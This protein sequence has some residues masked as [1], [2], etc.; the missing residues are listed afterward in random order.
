[1]GWERVGSPGAHASPLKNT[2]LMMFLISPVR[3][4]RKAGL[5]WSISEVRTSWLGG[6]VLH[7]GGGA[8]GLLAISGPAWGLVLGARLGRPHLNIEG[9]LA[10]G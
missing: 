6:H 10:R 2:W 7:L 8:D 4:R 1:M 5:W 3:Q 9:G